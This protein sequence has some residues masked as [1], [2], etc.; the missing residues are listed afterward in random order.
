MKTYDR[1]VARV[2]GRG[3]EP[4]DVITFENCTLC[5]VFE[6]FSSTYGGSSEWGERLRCDVV[7]GGGDYVANYEI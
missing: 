2:Y 7:E 1:L 5:D 4:L 3:T 6:H